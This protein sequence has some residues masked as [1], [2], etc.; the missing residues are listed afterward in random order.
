MKQRFPKSQLIA[1]GLV[2]THCHSTYINT[3]TKKNVA[4]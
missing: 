2:D 1:T 4:V 3:N